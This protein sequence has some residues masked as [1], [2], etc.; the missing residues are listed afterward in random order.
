[1]IKVNTK[2]NPESRSL[3]I[4]LPIG[5]QYGL[6]EAFRKS[7]E[8]LQDDIDTYIVDIANTDFIDR[9]GIGMLML[10]NEFIKNKNS[11][12]KIINCPTATQRLLQSKGLQAGKFQ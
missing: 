2:F 8:N 6:Y 11:E 5:F 7:Y 9:S 4:K 12:I 3:N 10:L 1:M